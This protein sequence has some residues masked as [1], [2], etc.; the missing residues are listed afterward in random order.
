M[1][2]V[3]TPTWFPAGS[4][5]LTTPGPDDAS[6]RFKTMMSVN[7]GFAHPAC[8]RRNGRCRPKA[9][10]LWIASCRVTNGDELASI[11]F[12]VD[13]INRLPFPCNMLIPLPKATGNHILFTLGIHYILGVGPRLKGVVCADVHHY[14]GLISID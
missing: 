14:G 3:L 7:M 10:V 1:R 6:Q 5:V 2:G 8:W 9:D 11:P 4:Y 13:K 12:P